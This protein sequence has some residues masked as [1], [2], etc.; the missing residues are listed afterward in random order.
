MQ[1]SASAV[2][3]QGHVGLSF[4]YWEGHLW[5]QG[6]S[7]LQVYREKE[8]QGSHG[9]RNGETVVMEVQWEE[10]ETDCHTAHTKYT[11]KGYLI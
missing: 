6:E 8:G 10:I 2:Q 7:S 4:R 9:E 3:R 1:G 5:K 11:Y